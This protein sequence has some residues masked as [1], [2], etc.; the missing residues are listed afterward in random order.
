MPVY[1]IQAE[2]GGPCKI[3]HSMFPEGRLTDLQRGN[4]NRLRIV[5]LYE[6]AGKT[7]L[8]LHRTFADKRLCGEWFDVSPAQ[9][10]Q[11]VKKGGFGL[12]EERWG[13]PVDE[14]IA[15]LI[16]AAIDEHGGQARFGKAIGVSQQLL[17][18]IVTGR[19]SITAEVALKFERAGL[20]RRV[21]RPDLFPPPAKKSAA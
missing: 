21:L 16:R 17:S 9:I 2:N 18:R 12:S 5:A 20:S 4:P 3:G 19:A 6:G 15:R 14:E 7:E 13:G 1:V 11:A 10:K 8:H